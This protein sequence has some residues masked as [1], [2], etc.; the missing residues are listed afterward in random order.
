[1]YFMIKLVHELKKRP[2]VS[3]EEFQEFISKN[4]VKFLKKAAGL[5]SA[6]VKFVYSGYQVQELP[7]D[8]CIEM[9]FRNEDL[10]KKTI[11]SEEG[12]KVLEELGRVAEKSVFLFLKEKIVK[13]PET[14]PARKKKKGKK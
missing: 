10:F 8:C 1:M 5:R 9:E 4:Y 14:K 6:S 2:E 7:I 13:K 12:K 11:E 3:V